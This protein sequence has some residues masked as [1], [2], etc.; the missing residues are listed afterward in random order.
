MAEEAIRTSWEMVESE[1]SL[2][3]ERMSYIE[4]LQEALGKDCEKDCNSPWLYIALHILRNGISREDFCAAVA[5]GMRKES[6][7]FERAWPSF[8]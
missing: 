3:H 1:D 7:Y 6:E 2:G 5:K 4:I 8:C